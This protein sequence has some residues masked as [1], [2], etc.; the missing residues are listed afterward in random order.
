MKAA[1]VLVGFLMLLVVL[2]VAALFLLDWNDFKDEVASLASDFIGRDVA[3]GH[4]DVDPGWTTTITLGGLSVANPE[5]A[6]SPKFYEA[7]RTRVS[8]RVWPLLRMR[9]R[10]PE[11]DLDAPKIAMQRNAEGQA[12]WD[13][14]ALAGSPDDRLGPDTRSEFPSV[15]KLT[16]TNGEIS[17]DDTISAYNTVAIIAKAEGRAWEGDDLTLTADGQLSERPLNVS[18]VGGS[19]TRL[20]GTT[21]PYPV[22]LKITVGDSALSAVGTLREPLSMGGGSV[23][24]A[25]SGPT[26]DALFPIIPLPLP[27]TPPYDLAGTLTLENAVW[28][29]KGFSGRMGDSDL[30]GD[31]SIDTSGEKPDV[32]GDLVSRKLDLDDLGGLIGAQPDPDETANREQQQQAAQLEASDSLFP[33]TPIATDQ[34]NL[35]NMDIKLTATRVEDEILPV[36]RLVARFNLTDSRVLVRPFSMSIAGGEVSGEFA[37]NGRSEVPSADA[38]LKFQ[39]VDLQPFFQDT[40]F[41]QEMSGRFFGDIY[42]LGVGRSLN[43][44]MA[45]ARGGGWIGARDGSLSALIVEA[46]GLDV[47][48]ALAIVIGGDDRVPIRCGLIEFQGDG[49]IINL[50]RAI[51]DTT[52]SVLVA[53]GSVNTDAETLDVQVEARA[54]DFSLI[55]LAT[56]VLVKG[57]IA[58]PDISI[59]GLDPL[60]FFEI[61]DEQDVDCDALLANPLRP[62]KPENPAQ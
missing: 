21:E 8:I 56:P 30:S 38:D 36:D 39:N 6:A 32:T 34:L 4:L 60:P 11:V 54:K 13:F 5:W 59:G 10:M 48:E 27:E 53:K 1:A 37:L 31:L 28:S 24:L 52:D 51:V 18:F 17:F 9:I 44:L 25:I 61:G 45:G 41:A 46:I 26:L 19:M 47:I 35:A 16:V 43:D 12:T 3:I 50:N 22:D 33:D 57:R 58:D 20:R 55:D 14:A 23:K 7:D 29:L 49:G 40:D 62:A 2:G 15:G 42:F